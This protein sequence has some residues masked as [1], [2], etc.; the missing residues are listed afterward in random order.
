MVADEKYARVST[1]IPTVNIWC[2]HTTNPNN[3][4]AIIANIIPKLPNAS[5]FLFHDK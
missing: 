4:S 3:P 5:F 2:A 1:S